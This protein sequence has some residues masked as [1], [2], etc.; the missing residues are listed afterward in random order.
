MKRNQNPDHNHSRK[1]LSCRYN[2]DTNRVEARFADIIW[3]NEPVTSSTLVKLAG[4]QLQWKRTTVHTVLRRLCDKGLFRNDNGMVTSLIS[5]DQF[6][7][8]QS[9]QFVQTAFHGS[10]PAFL[11]AFSRSRPLTDAE[12]ELVR[13][14]ID[15]VEEES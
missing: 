1:V 9:E 7:S 2:M 14:M 15:S 8:M 6:Y 4:E 5:R 3:E 13:Q 11:A 12:R 10:F